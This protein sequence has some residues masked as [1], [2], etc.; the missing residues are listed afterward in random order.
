MANFQIGYDYSMDA[1][2]EA[3]KDKVQVLDDKWFIK[4]FVD[5]QHGTL[6]E[7]STSKPI[8]SY[9]A[10]LKKHNL[11]IPYTKST[12]GVQG[13]GKG[14]GKDKVKGKVISEEFEKFW[15]VYP[16]KKGKDNALRA[17]NNASHRPKIDELIAVVEKHKLGHDWMKDGGKYIHL[18]ATWLNGGCWDDVITPHYKEMPKES[19]LSFQEK[20][21]IRKQKE[22]DALCDASIVGLV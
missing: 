21:K 11:W 4:S 19:D 7:E 9:I 20:E 6:D 2:L 3:F 10:L 5:Y 17:F 14:K 8:I 18:P 13:K 22:S 16:R 12:Q 15:A 1:L